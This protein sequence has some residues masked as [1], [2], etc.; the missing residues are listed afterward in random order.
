M[1]VQV[2]FYFVIWT[3]RSP[4]IATLPKCA[5]YFRDAISRVLIL[6]KLTLEHRRT[7]LFTREELEN[8]EIDGSSAAAVLK[9]IE[10][11]L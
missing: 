5:I 4:K 10:V 11:N 2:K 7:S 8:D 1:Q 9:L 3:R 6:T